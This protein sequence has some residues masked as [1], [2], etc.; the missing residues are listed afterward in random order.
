[1]IMIYD[2]AVVGGGP[3][4]YVAA[5][6]SAQLGAKVLL[7]EKDRIGGVCLN[8]G[9]IPT[10]TLLKS[11]DKWHELKNC[12]AFGLKAENIGFDFAAVMKRKDEVVSQL[13]GGI[14]KLVKSNN[15]DIVNGRAALRGPQEI[16]VTTATGTDLFKAA[17]IILAVGS[18]SVDLPVPGGNLPGVI[19]SDQLLSLASV[20]ESMVVVGAGAVGIEFAAILQAF[21]CQVTVVEMA[22]SILPNIDS[23]IVK[24]MGVVLR[25]QGLQMLA[26]TKVRQI[27][28]GSTGLIVEVENSK[29]V[30]EIATEKVLAAIGR[31]PAL[32]GLGLEAAGVE[33]SAKGIPVNAKMATNV[34][35]IYAIGDVT[36]QFMWAHAASAEGIIAAE[37]AMGGSKVM[38]YS[39]VPGCIFTSPEIAVVGVSEQEAAASGKKLLISK[40]NFAANGKAV[41]MGETEGMVKIIADAETHKMIGMHLFGPHASDLIMEGAIAIKNGLTAEEIGQTI[42]PHPSLSETVMETAHGIS[43]DIIHQ[44]KIGRTR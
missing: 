12:A 8:R 39:A 23:D 36:G 13:Q 18:V 24:R 21:G 1:M 5:I 20:P 38:D 34:E 9:C 29:G 28:T 3:G 17:K 32:G 30:Q 10:K 25:K 26:G 14:V 16:E 7:V 35:G 19:D 31:K 11:A 40:L 41:S 4:G 44:L 43:G 33:Y 37:N 6:R 27:K 22:P 42:H 2:V 15:I